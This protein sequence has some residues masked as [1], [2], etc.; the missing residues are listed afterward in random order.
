L[1]HARE[2]DSVLVTRSIEA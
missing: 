1:E 2:I